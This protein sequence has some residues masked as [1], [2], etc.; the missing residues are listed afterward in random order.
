MRVHDPIASQ[1]FAAHS[2]Q[3]RPLS[4]SIVMRDADLGDREGSGISIHCDAHGPPTAAI[5][6]AGVFHLLTQVL[7][8]HKMIC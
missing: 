7:S 3:S 8:A 4:K 2:A 5:P 6:A 1:C